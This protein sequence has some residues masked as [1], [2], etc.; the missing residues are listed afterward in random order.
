MSLQSSIALAQKLIKKN[1]RLAT[2]NQLGAGADPTKPWKADAPVIVATVTQPAVFLPL[3]SD[4]GF[5]LTQDDLEKRATEAILT[6]VGALDLTLVHQVVD[7]ETYT[8]LWT[9]ILK[10][11][12]LPVLYAMGIAR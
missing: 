6:G 10:P 9:K 3:D 2:F 4:L 12:T 1:G 5:T 11:G 7:G 8:I